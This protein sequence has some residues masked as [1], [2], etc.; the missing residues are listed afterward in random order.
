V[1]SA[2]TVH[3]LAERLGVAMPVCDQMYK[4]VTGEIS[5]DD[6]YTGLRTPAGHEA[7]PG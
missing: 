5:P 6:A 4:V 7:D 3:E 2:V 1:K